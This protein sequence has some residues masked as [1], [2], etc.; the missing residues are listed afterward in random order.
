MRHI[1]GKMKQEKIYEANEALGIDYTV[2]PI[3][4]ACCGAVDNMMWNSLIGDYY[5]A[6][7][8]TWQSEYIE[9]EENEG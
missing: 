9:G 6:W 5:C 3:R 4:C 1:R 7:C 8:E 2:S